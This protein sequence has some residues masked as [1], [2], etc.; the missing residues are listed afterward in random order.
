[1]TTVEEHSRSRRAEAYQ[2]LL[3]RA[4][5]VRLLAQRIDVDEINAAIAAI[6]RAEATGP[7]SDP[8]LFREAAGFMAQDRETLV[9]VRDLGQLYPRAAAGGAD[10]RSRPSASETA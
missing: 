7:I 8:T 1:M 2:A 10:E 5:G 3:R 4:H 9:A 6:D